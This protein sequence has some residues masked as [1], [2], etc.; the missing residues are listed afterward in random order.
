MPE[1][2]MPC[3]LYQPL[4]PLRGGLLFGPFFCFLLQLHFRFFNDGPIRDF[5]ALGHIIA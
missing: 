5:P 1:P 4:M 2:N 3:F